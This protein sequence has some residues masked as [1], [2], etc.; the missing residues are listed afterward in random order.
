MSSF[1]IIVVGAGPGGALAADYAARS[2]ASVIVL[3]RRKDV[4]V[5]V[6]C[7]ELTSMGTFDEFSLDPKGD[8]IARELQNAR[9]I[10]PNGKSFD[11][12]GIK[13]GILNR[14]IL[15]KH[16][17]ERAVNSGAT[18]KLNR[19]VVSGDK[20]GVKL[21]NGK[22]IKG[23]IVI[24]AD[25]VKS[26]IGKSAGIVKKIP[27]KDLGVAVKYMVKSNKIDGDRCIV[28]MGGEGLKGYTWV[29]PKG[30]NSANVGLGSIGGKRGNLKPILDNFIERNYPGAEK[31]HYGAGALPLARPPD[32]TVKDN[33]MLVGDAASM[34]NAFGGAGIRNAMM[35]GK[36][37]G[38]LAGK[39][40][41]EKLP[42]SYLKKY[43]KLWRKKILKRLKVNLAVKELVWE[44][45]GSLSML[46]W[47]ITPLHIIID[48][49]PKI[50][51]WLQE[52]QHM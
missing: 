52:R 26:T 31:H 12:T 20:S 32:I 27:Q 8:W 3:D 21:K 43:E 16:L 30:N 10:F 2:G 11:V 51:K 35:A 15:E 41:T 37:A 24:A 19:T 44:R 45:P 39:C 5:P 28:Y 13:M 38:S 18:L 50:L 40:I 42:L 4:G 22:R 6:I 14:D 46:P 33:L 9:V 23:K 49:N 47:L 25:G 36:I 34:V 1:D 7:G 17:I 29:F 48:R